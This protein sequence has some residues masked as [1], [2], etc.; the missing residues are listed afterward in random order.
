MVSQNDYE[1]SNFGENDED[2]CDDDENFG[3]E[4]GN[5]HGDFDEDCGW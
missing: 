5:C 1:V 4:N 2:V 3:D